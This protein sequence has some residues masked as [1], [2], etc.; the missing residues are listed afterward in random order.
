[1][2]EIGSGNTRMIRVA[3][4]DAGMILRESKTPDKV[5]VMACLPRILATVWN[6]RVPVVLVVEVDAREADHEIPIYKNHYALADI[7]GWYRG[8]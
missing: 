1:M 3:T 8:L 7:I 4:E 5:D 2:Q 6:N